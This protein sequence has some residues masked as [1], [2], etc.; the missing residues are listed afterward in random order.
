MCEFSR[1]LIAWMDGELSEGETATIG[2]HVKGC[3]ECR[4]RMEGYRQASDGFAAYCD[5]A[6]AVAVVEPRAKIP[7]W[8]FVAAGAAVALF[9]VFSQPKHLKHSPPTEGHPA[10]AVR[11]APLP[12]EARSLARSAAELSARRPKHV[13]EKM[14]EPVLA[15][16]A[17]QRMVAARAPVRSAESLSGEP[18]I[19][20]A[21]PADA[22]F[23]PGAVP[24]G[25]SFTA[26]LTISADGS[27]EQLGLRPRLA[28]FERRV[29][30]Q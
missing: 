11:A 26:E 10:A 2:A 18:S 7:P 9:V 24:A 12:A 4:S 3:P 13:P 19:E 23:P 27:A 1:K 21:I 8:V 5:A 29:N 17:A 22:M 20:I 28:G 6:V 14:P 15:L 16:N 30:Q 25:M